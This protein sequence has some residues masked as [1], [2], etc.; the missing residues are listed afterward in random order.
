MKKTQPTNQE[1][2]NNDDY[3]AVLTPA[4]KVDTNHYCK[5]QQSTAVSY[6]SIEKTDTLIDS[7]LL[8]VAGSSLN[9]CRW[10]NHCNSASFVNEVV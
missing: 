7:I 6:N 9:N 5:C 4:Q 3:E 1:Q 8:M 10:I 2:Q